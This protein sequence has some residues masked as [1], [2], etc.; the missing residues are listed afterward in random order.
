MENHRNRKL[1][2]TRQKVF[3]LRR[4]H[5]SDCVG[6][7]SDILGTSVRFRSESLF[8][9]SRNECSFSVGTCTRRAKAHVAL[10]FAGAAF[11][12]FGF[13]LAALRPTYWLFGL[14]LI[15]MGLSAQ[16]LTTTVVS[17]V[18][19]STDPNMRGRV[20]AILLAIALGGAPLAPPS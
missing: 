14:A 20:M 4:N 13:A 8:A 2:N 18:Q 9:F 12:G 3:D 19:L 16:T 10:L 6:I 17:T 1:A 7:C 5:R 15:V 11:F